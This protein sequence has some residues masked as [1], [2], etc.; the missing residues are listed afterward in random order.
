MYPISDDLPSRWCADQLASL[1]R[2]LWHKMAR[3]LLLVL[4]VSDSMRW[5]SR[6]T[7][8]IC[9]RSSVEVFIAYV[10]D[11]RPSG[12]ILAPV[13]P[14]HAIQSLGTFVCNSFKISSASFLLTPIRDWRYAGRYM[15]EHFVRS[16]TIDR[17]HYCHFRGI[18]R[19]VYSAVF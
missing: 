15:V 14:C 3:S 8:L 10:K 19:L 2:L 16:T 5:E 6:E 4:H 11:K 17:R 1:S 12:A 9:S 18:S 7:T 13:A